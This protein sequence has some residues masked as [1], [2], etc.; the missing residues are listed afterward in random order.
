MAIF[1]GRNELEGLKICFFVCENLFPGPGTEMWLGTVPKRGFGT[2][3]KTWLGTVPK[4][5]SVH[6]PKCGWVPYWNVVWYDPAFHLFTYIRVHVPNPVSVLYSTTFWYI[7]RTT[8]CY[9]TFKNTSVR[10]MASKKILL[11]QLKLG[12]GIWKSGEW[13]YCDIFSEISPNFAI[14]WSLNF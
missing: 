4:R 1:Y 13:K 10:H 14:F 3:T 8:F 6:V 2:C 9:Q 7:Y 12:K 11:K 5:G